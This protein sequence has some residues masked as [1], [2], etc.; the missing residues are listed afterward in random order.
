MWTLLTVTQSITRNI[1][2]GTDIKPYACGKSAFRFMIPYDVIRGNVETMQF[3]SRD[4][5]ITFW[6]A[7]DRRMVMYPCDDNTMMNFVGIHPS[8]LSSSARDSGE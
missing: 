8:E 7:K 2:S 1:V 6:Y 5:Y 4:G 3:A